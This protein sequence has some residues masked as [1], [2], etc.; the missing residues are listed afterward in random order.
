MG[1]IGAFAFLGIACFVALIATE[2]RKGP[3]GNKRVNLPPP[4]SA[5]DRKYDAGWWS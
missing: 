3:R 5:C 1:I 2:V 4:S